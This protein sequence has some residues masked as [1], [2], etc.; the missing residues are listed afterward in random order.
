MMSLLQLGIKSFRILPTPFH[1]FL[2]NKD[3]S[4]EYYFIS[5]YKMKKRWLDTETFPEKN[6]L[7]QCVSLFHT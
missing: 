3:E 4:I 1:S 5:Y 2:Q 6:H 7:S